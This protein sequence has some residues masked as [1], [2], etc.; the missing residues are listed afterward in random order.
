MKAILRSFFVLFVFS[1]L[2]SCD[3][4]YPKAKPVCMV[5]PDLQ[6]WGNPGDYGI[7]YYTDLDK[8]KECS[9]STGRKILLMFTFYTANSNIGHEWKILRTENVRRLINDQFVFVVLYVDDPTKLE[10]VDSIVL[11]HGKIAIK[12]EGMRNSALEELNFH[13]N[14][15]PLYAVVDTSLHEIV[16]IMGYTKDSLAFEEMLLNSLKTQ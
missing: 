4:K 13:Q 1:S 8:A 6:Q 12:T 7:T 14:S 15:Q 9:A 2:G 5:S 10:V 11:Q 16:P 3:S